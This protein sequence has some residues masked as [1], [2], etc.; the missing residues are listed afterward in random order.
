MGASSPF[1]DNDVDQPRCTT[2]PTEGGGVHAACSHPTTRPPHL[3]ISHNLVV[4]VE[5]KEQSIMWCTRRSC[6]SHL[7]ILFPHVQ[8][9]CTVQ[10]LKVLFIDVQCSTTGTAPKGAVWMPVQRRGHRHIIKSWVARV[11]RSSVQHQGGSTQ[12]SLVGGRDTSV[13]VTSRLLPEHGIVCTPSR[14]ARIQPKWGTRLHTGCLVERRWTSH[15]AQRLHRRRA[16]C[17]CS[18]MR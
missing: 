14:V 6:H 1:H 10:F 5:W 8:H 15:A 4:K 3:P 7:R 2:H 13:T 18:G 17:T 16:C 12:C 9:S 11:S